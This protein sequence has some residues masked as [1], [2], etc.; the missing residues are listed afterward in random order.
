MT[1]KKSVHFG[2]TLCQ[3]EVLISKLEKEEIDTMESLYIFENGIA[4]TRDA[5]KN[6]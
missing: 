4:L 3:L 6:S 1:K 2:D 5:Q